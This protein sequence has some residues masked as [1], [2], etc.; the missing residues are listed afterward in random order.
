MTL[1]NISTKTMKTRKKVKISELEIGDFVSDLDRAWCDTPFPIQGFYI[2]SSEDQSTLAKYCKCVEIDVS[3]TRV[4][5]KVKSKSDEADRRRAKLK[6]IDEAPVRISNPVR[7]EVTSNLKR[8]LKIAE[9]VYAQLE[10]S[11]RKLEEG[12]RENFENISES[13][14][15]SVKRSLDAMVKSVVRNPDAIL[16]LSKMAAEKNQFLNHAINA[17]ALALVFGRHIG[18]SEGKLQSLGLG[19]LFA[20]VGQLKIES[21]AS[22]NFTEK[23]L[24]AP[25]NAQ[26]LAD[27][28]SYIRSSLEM[29]A[30]TG[31]MNKK[32]AEVICHHREHFDGTGFPNKFSGKQIPLLA[33][34]ASIVIQYEELTSSH[35]L[36]LSSTDAI[37]KLY[38]GRAKKYQGTLVEAFIRSVGL[39]PPGSAVQLD[40]GRIGFVTSVHH[41]RMLSPKV[42]LMF[43]DSGVRLAKP[44]EVDLGEKLDTKHGRL[45]VRIKKALSSKDYHCDCEDLLDKSF[46]SVIGF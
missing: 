30:K 31:L 28:Y 45:L 36:A 37:A 21:K 5:P 39:Y 10:S 46:L 13:K 23:A 14:L 6:C 4:K 11:L 7:Y 17:S 34:I 29:T 19:V 16:I 42:K 22:Q 15:V 1:Q 25:E 20:K 12:L 38:Q 18:L 2:Q 3:K 9:K 24:H 41:S 32:V 33:R 43:D 40:D 27:K 35:G 44:F 26:A 8:E